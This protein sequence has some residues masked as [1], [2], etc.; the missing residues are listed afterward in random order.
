MHA[1]VLIIGGGIAGLQLANK[2]ANHL[3]VIVLT[4][5]SA[6]N[7]NSYLAQGGI[8]ASL[9]RDDNYIKHAADT[10]EAG[11]YHNKV[12]VVDEITKAA[13]KLI[14]DLRNS[15]CSFD[16]NSK[17]ELLLG[18]EGAHSDNRIVHSGG[19]ATGKRIIGFFHELNR[20]IKIVENVFVYE[21]LVNTSTN[22][23]YGVKAKNE[24]GK[25]ITIYGNHTVLATGG[26]GKLYSYSSN[27]SSV[28][29]D[30]I[31][32]AY[33]AGATITDMEFVQFHPTLLYVNGTTVGL[34]SEAVRGEGGRL[35]SEKGTYIMEKVH[36]FKD[37]APRH[38]VSQEIY[39]YL[40]QGEN[41]YLDITAIPDFEKRFPSITKLC[42][43]NGIDI[44]KG[45][46]PVAPGCHFLMGGIEVDL[47]GRTSVE[48]LYAI[49][50]VSCTGLHGANR[51]ASN[52]L[53]EGLYM[54]NKLANLLK[55][56]KLVDIFAPYQLNVISQKRKYI[57]QS[58]FP[59]LE[60]LQNQMMEN[61]GIVRHETKLRKQLYWL[62]EFG[63]TETFEVP[64]EYSSPKEMEMYFML[65]TSWL[66]TK[67]AIDR[68]ESRGGH[69]RA[70][71]PEE[72][73]SW[74]KSKIRHKR[75]FSK[76]T[77]H[78]PIKIAEI[79]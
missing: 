12:D 46:L 19:D 57:S 44:E 73:E 62:E 43:E 77:H 26:C 49:G 24:N 6:T 39:Q 1:D 71:Y 67:S 58:N 69:Y 11:R 31:A 5:S 37:L 20:H 38:I 53:L 34:V 8:A 16:E 78:E 52:S 48:N 21:L 18:M 33:L 70:D 23:C 45:K 13:P 27:A 61:V 79:T 64:T 75:Y 63:I 3:N 76:E 65:V 60:E 68:L 30:G 72:Q 50:E 4:K 40:K 66:I 42:R 54:G 47:Y 74:R 9:G 22:T 17:G 32:L 28:T 15:G 35:V 36:P 25:S 55:K 29:G 56:K 7:S 2:L 51:L 10:L 14:Q 59:S 41:V